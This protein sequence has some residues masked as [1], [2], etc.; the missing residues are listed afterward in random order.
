MIAVALPEIRSAFDLSHTELGW[1]ISA[2]LI[3][4]A[5]SQ[6]VGGQIGD[7]VGHARLF[8]WGLIAF[9]LCSLAGALSPS[10]LVLVALR[11][12]QAITGAALV[13]T[14]QAMLRNAFETR[15]LGRMIGVN[16]AVMS[17]AAAAGPLVGA[18]L[19]AVG[20]WRLLFVINAPVI[21][22]AALLLRRLDRD[23]QRSSAFGGV[24][25]LP[26]IALFTTSLILMTVFLAQLAAGLDLAGAL[27]GGAAAIALALFALQ[28]RRTRVAVAAWSLFRVR[29]FTAASL[30]VMLT[31]FVMYTTLLYIPFLIVET[32]GGASGET[33]L[34]LGAMTVLM[35]VLA[36][37]AGTI[38]DRH[39]R[40]VPALAGATLVLI[41]SLA[42]LAAVAA[43]SSLLLLALTLALLGLG[44]GLGAGPAMTA[45]VESAPPEASGAAAGTSSMMRYLGSILGAGV[46][47]GL[48]GSGGAEAADIDLF[49][50]LAGIVVLTAAVVVAVS[51]LIHRFPVESPA[52]FA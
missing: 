35:A 21:L 48:L 49:R 9:L 22:V 29:S 50:M 1:I 41:A 26:R 51:P 10:F 47:A 15:R 12:G 24:M 3:A 14:G 44:V 46:L 32:R 30:H 11:T 23:G 38:A 17:V 18:A 8:R 52:S 6:P 25:D 33:G 40:R 20:S 19:L 43:D 45:A 42:L 34:L 36:P 37:V 5:V 4:M 13:P 28:Q 27:A 7:R 16:G 39:G 31:N 2:Y